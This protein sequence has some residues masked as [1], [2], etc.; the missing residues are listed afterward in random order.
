MMRIAG[1]HSLRCFGLVALGCGLL[2]VGSLSGQKAPARIGSVPELLNI[3]RDWDKEGKDEAKQFELLRK[4]DESLTEDA[5][6]ILDNAAKWY[7]YRL[8][9]PRYQEPAGGKSMHE[10]VKQAVAQLLDPRDQKKPLNANQQAF[11]EEFGK[12]LTARLEEVSKNRKEIARVNAAMILGELAAIGV[13]EA[14]DV[15]VDIILDPNEN[16]GVR[17][18]AFHGFKK[19][20]TFA[21]A[22]DQKPFKNKDRENRCI[23][24]LLAYLDRKPSLP[25]A[26]PAEVAAVNYVRSEAIAALGQT[27]LPAST[28]P[29][30]KKTII[31]RPTALALLRVMRKDGV[32]IQPSIREQVNACVGLCQLKS[33]R[34]DEYQP[35]YAAYHIGF[36]VAEFT[37]RYNSPTKEVDKVNVEKKT[38]AG[39]KVEKVVTKEPWKIDAAR[40]HQALDELKE[41]TARNAEAKYIA[42]L[43][44]RAQPLLLEIINGGMGI[45]PRNLLTYLDQNPPKSATVYKDDA[46]AKI[47]SEPEKTGE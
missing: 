34:C 7:A 42:S 9:D 4:G 14:A 40:I 47:T 36:F 37:N 41:D 18:F 13:E 23:G 35:D 27:N 43:V 11:L 12:R 32:P 16:D 20:F 39:D 6:K 3:D 38:K 10:L 29:V 2:S 1:R 33:R 8:T 31:E 24:A 30:A 28:R 25:P 45:D 46:T 21:R 19:L 44:S 17:F 5:K 22:E 15:L 26:T